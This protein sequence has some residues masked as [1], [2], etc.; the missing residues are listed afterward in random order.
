MSQVLQED[1][2]E[3]HP[4]LLRDL[5]LRLADARS[6]D[7]SVFSWGRCLPSYPMHNIREL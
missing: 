7:F 5:V 2:C 6:I 3:I 1:A 4:S